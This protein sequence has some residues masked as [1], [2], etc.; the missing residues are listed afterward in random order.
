MPVLV[1]LPRHRG[2]HV[3]QHPIDRGEHA[4]GEL[5][6]V[7]ELPASGQVEGHDAHLLGVYGCP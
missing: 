2:E 4:R 5:I 7:R 3:Q 6:S 1:V